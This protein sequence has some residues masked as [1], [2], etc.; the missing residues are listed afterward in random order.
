MVE[1][2]KIVELYL[3]RNEQAISHT[4]EKYGTRIRNLAKRILDSEQLAEECENDTYFKTW[5]SIPPHE[6]RTYFMPF[7]GKIT[8]QLALDVCKK[9]HRIKRSASYC[10]LT[11]ELQE[12]L[13]S[14]TSTEDEVEA[15]Y[16]GE[17]L[18]E[19]I[20]KYSQEQQK[21]F[22]RRYWFFDPVSEIAN[23]YGFTE[24]KVKTT[25]FRMRADLKEYLEKGGFIL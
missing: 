4:A 15:K 2:E 16:L 19:F 11:Q 12:C 17:L 3:A 24:S 23:G 22:V 13:P 1:D 7:I 18:T 25:L 5:N 6:P 20:K 21:I 9:N 8:R 14:G 10:E